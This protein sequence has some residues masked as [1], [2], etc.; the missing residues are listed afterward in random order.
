MVSFF[1]I[2][3][4]Q[5]YYRQRK[6]VPHLQLP[7]AQRLAT[8]VNVATVEWLALSTQYRTDIFIGADCLHEQVQSVFCLKAEM[9][10]EKEEATTETAAIAT[11]K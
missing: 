10:C 9:K 5:R 8:I 4:E 3:S 6:R 11:E 2:I 1:F 7:F